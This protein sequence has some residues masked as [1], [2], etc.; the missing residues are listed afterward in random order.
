MTQNG[1]KSQ[2]VETLVFSHADQP[3]G[4]HIRTTPELTH[5]AGGTTDATLGDFLSRPVEIYT[6]T[7]ATSA[8]LSINI[9]PWRKFL[10]DPR[11][12]ARVEGFKHLRGNMMVR[13]TITG[14]PMMYG[15]LILAYHPRW[16]RSV[17]PLC[18][19]LSEARNMQFSQWPHVFLDPTSGEGGEM[20][21]PFFCP[22]NWIDLTNTTSASDMGTLFLHTFNRI[23]H[24]NSANGTVH[25]KLYVWMENVELCQPTAVSYSQIV[26]QAEDSVEKSAGPISSTLGAVAK[27]AGALSDVPAIAPYALATEM[28]AKVLGKAARAFGFSRPNIVTNSAFYHPLHH[29]PLSTMDTDIHAVRL[30]VEAKG[31]LSIDPRTVG[32]PD[33]DEMQIKYIAQR[34]SFFHDSTWEE[35]DIPKTALV[36]IAVTPTQFETDSS[37]LTQFRS[38][39]T[40]TAAV[41]SLFDYWRGTL[42]YRFQIIAS[43]FHRGK[44]RVSYDP[45][46]SAVTNLENEV[47]SRIIDLEHT[48]D[49][50]VPIKWNA[51]TPWLKVPTIDVGSTTF[52]FSEGPRAAAPPATC[53]GKI[54]VEVENPLTSPDPSLGRSITV[55]CFIRA[56]DDFELA[57]P[58]ARPHSEGWT[59]KSTQASVE[60]QALIDADDAPQENNPEGGMA[61]DKIGTYESPEADPMNKVFFGETILSLR[62]FLKRFAYMGGSNTVTKNNGLIIQARDSITTVGMPLQ[63]YIMNM[64]VG[65][66]GSMRFTADAF[67]TAT[68]TPVHLFLSRGTKTHTDPASFA[69]LHG[70]Y[71]TCAVDVPY[72]Y[73]K[74]FSHCRTQPTWASDTDTDPYDPNDALS[75]TA[76]TKTGA[77]CSV[78]VFKA[79]GEDFSLF[80]FLGLPAI[81]KV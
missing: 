12:K 70:N 7:L 35:L 52:F 36:E 39:L 26:E 80:F 23:K 63:E 75:V 3:T 46:G 67:Y 16:E 21:L 27:A 81:F 25:L 76:S 1:S 14:N 31:E 5:H 20:C 56:G 9:N 37:G 58:S 11:V 59:F 54:T 57:V 53:N 55:N 8:D 42:I 28:G 68:G 50:E 51:R 45:A 74:R 47:Y 24:A 10:D 40:P 15:K 19:Q 79:A 49:F 44:I 61:V 17:F 29:P 72:Y 30:G 78:D 65:W 43:A 2:K 6:T 64:Y 33:V 60:P 41:S 32:L 62:Q 77:S 73:N 66:R 22:E 38:V 71:A 69:G 4:T 34:E 18:G 13:A 48:R